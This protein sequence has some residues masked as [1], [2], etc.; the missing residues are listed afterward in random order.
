MVE[1]TWPK[2]YDETVT[3]FHKIAE[4]QYYLT[5][6]NSGT[7]KSFGKSPIT[8]VPKPEVD[9]MDWEPT[10]TTKLNAYTQGGGN[11][12]GNPKGPSL[13]NGEL[14]VGKRARWVS[15]EEINRRK[16]EKV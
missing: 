5:Q 8:S 3:L 1:R 12:N 16:A 13:P 2:T 4:D 7:T 6:R 14:L 15:R 9:V 10:V 11:P